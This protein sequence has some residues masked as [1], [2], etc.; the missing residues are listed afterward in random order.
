MEIAVSGAEAAPAHLVVSE[1]W[2]KDWTAEVDGKPGI[3]RRA[4]HSLLS[5]DLPPGAKRVTLTFA[6]PEYA[7]GKMVSLVSLLLALGWVG[8]GVLSDRRRA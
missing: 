5:V 6:S 8:A 1:N 7:T 3:V 2:Y 4:D